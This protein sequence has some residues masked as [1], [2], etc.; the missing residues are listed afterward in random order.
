MIEGRFRRPQRLIRPAEFRRVFAR[1]CKVSS[2]YALILAR[3]NSLT[4]GRLGLA[5]AKRHVKTAVQR[6]RIKRHARESFRAHAADLAG[7]DCVV[8]ARAGLDRLSDRELRRALD[9]LWQEL[10]QRCRP[11]SCS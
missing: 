3:D 8:L 9:A 10:I 2:R 4:R 5:I 6:N 7:L 1:P 11:F